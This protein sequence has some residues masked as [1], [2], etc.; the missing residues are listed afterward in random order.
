MSY[1]SKYASHIT[2]TDDIIAGNRAVKFNLGLATGFT[3]VALLAA[4]GFVVQHGL[5]WW[6]VYLVGGALF[7]LLQVGG[8]PFHFIDQVTPNDRLS[9]A[10]RSF[11]IYFRV[12]FTWPQLVGRAAYQNVREVML[13]DDDDFR[14]ARMFAS[15]QD[16]Q[17]L[18]EFDDLPDE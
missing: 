2:I 4:V 8:S 9:P 13:R 1:P 18:G 3:V 5:T 6:V 16:A 11:A 10:T 15:I 17:D 14:V 12:L 7:A